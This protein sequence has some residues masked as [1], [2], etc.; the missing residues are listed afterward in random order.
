MNIHDA[1]Y[2]TK[3]VSKTSLIPFGLRDILFSMLWVFNIEVD[4]QKTI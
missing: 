1:V 2:F 4:V 3:K